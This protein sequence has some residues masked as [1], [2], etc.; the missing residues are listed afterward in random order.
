MEKLRCQDLPIVAISNANFTPVLAKS[1]QQ[2]GDRMSAAQQPC[3]R[4]VDNYFWS[5][6]SNTTRNSCKILLDQLNFD[7]N[8]F[9]FTRCA[10]KWS[11]HKLSNMVATWRWWC[12]GCWSNWRHC[13]VQLVYEMVCS[14][15]MIDLIACVAQMLEISTTVGSR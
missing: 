8:G 7:T 12:V 2:F 11:F 9:N 5:G 3:R 15:S 13:D 6:V 1:Y 4:V 10:D 14:A